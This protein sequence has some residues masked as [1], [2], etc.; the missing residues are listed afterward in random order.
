LEDGTLTEKPPSSD[1][2]VGP[3]CCED[4]GLMPV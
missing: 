2:P 4:I 1:W 3:V